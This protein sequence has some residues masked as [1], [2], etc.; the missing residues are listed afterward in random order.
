PITGNK[1]FVRLTGGWLHTCGL[2]A[3]GVAY[4]W[5]S[6]LN[7]Q[8]GN[9]DISL[10]T[11]S[12]SA[13][14]TLPITGNK[15]FVHLTAGGASTCGL[16]ADGV[17][18]CWGSDLNG[19]LGNSGAAVGTQSPSA[20]DTLL[21]TG[22]KAFVRL[23]AGGYHTCGLA[24]DGVAYCW[25]RDASG[26]LGNGGTSADT[27]SPSPVDTSLIPGNKTFVQLTAG[28]SHTCGLTADGV[29]YCWGHDQYGQLG[30]SG[31]L[32]DT[33]SP[34]PVDTST[35]T[36]N[37]AFVHLTAGGYHTC[38]LA[39]DGVAHCWGRDASGQLGNG[40][41]SDDTQSASAVDT[42]SIGN[43]A[44]VH[45]TAG[46]NHTCG[47]TADGVAYCW[48]SDG[49]GQ[50]GT[51]GTF[52]DEQS[53]SA[54]DTS[55]IAGNKAFVELTAGTGHTCGL[56]A[57]RVAYCW[58]ADLYGQ[59]GNGVATAETQSPSA[60]DTSLM[61]VKTFVQ[62]TAGT[63][64]TCGLTTDGVAHC[65]G[66]DASGQLG[67]GGAAQQRQSPS[68]VTTSPITDN[69]AIVQLTAG[70]W[71][72]C[73]VTADG[74][75]Y[76]WGSDGT[77]QLGNGLALVDPMQSP[78]AVDTVPISGNKAPIQ[79]IGGWFHTCGLT[80]DGEA[81]CWGWDDNGQL[82]N[83]G[84]SANTHSPSAVDTSAL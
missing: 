45:L 31:A 59:L 12:P 81:Y 7:G 5:G 29:A 56:T 42:S 35:I 51:G 15:A 73:C 54:V 63:D 19:Q 32:A 44:F 79:L 9:G 72:T 22:N 39:A 60:V 47:R 52:F 58:G 61:A 11:Q 41:S 21:I 37:R 49:S 64:H 4:C 50:L 76:C 1:A 16:T 82:G 70:Y 84:T 48:G 71:H 69:K 53:P 36:G 14:E 8:L 30:N 83:G 3:D 25:G 2:T 75:A 80:A 34:S 26:Q 68:V 24:A 66:D 20:V 46:S 74:V 57:N 65:W 55:P 6:D 13:V 27:Q 77:G 43:K 78:S 62:L 40:G 67:N 38:G 28:G 10:D 33:Q 17:A 18:Y 23:A